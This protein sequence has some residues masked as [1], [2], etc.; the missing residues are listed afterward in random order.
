MAEVPECR[1]RLSGSKSVQWRGGTF[2]TKR[3]K[4]SKFG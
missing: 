4:K 1:G 3:Q 2:S